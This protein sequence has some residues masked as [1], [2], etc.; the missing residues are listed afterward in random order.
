MAHRPSSV[1][2]IP[3]RG[4]SAAAGSH[5]SMPAAGRAP[6][7]SAAAAPAP[8]YAPYAPPSTTT[9]AGAPPPS[10]LE[11][12][13][14]QQQQPPA[15]FKQLYA[16]VPMI[17]KAALVLAL[18]AAG[19]FLLGLLLII[20]PFIGWAWTLLLWVLAVVL[21]IAGGFCWVA[22]EA[23]KSMFSAEKRTQLEMALM[24]NES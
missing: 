16:E 11:A 9:A 10:D 7:S 19:A 8:G 17:R 22:P 14:D 18:A 15:E 5:Y 2:A 13:Y 20:V 3:P 4:A 21:A 23:Y 12:N 1:P 24:T 6:P